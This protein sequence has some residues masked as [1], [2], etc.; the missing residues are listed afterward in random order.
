MTS[1]NGNIRETGKFIY[2]GSPWT[3]YGRSY[4]I[5]RFDFIRAQISYDGD[6]IPKALHTQRILSLILTEPH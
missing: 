1:E 5:T 6:I 3:E 4:K 2:E